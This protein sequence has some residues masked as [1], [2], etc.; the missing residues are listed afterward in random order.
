MG[1]G[2]PNYVGCK[3]LLPSGFHFEYLENKL[4]HY[5]DKQIIQFLRYGFPVDHNRS[6]GVN[7][8]VSNHK[9]ASEFAIQVKEALDREV[10]MG[11]SLG[12]FA[13]AP[14]E[15]TCFSPLNSV[16]K[17]NVE[18]RRL[19]LDLSFPEHNSIN[20]GI[21]KHT[22][23]GVPD[24]MELPSIDKLVERIVKLGKGCK[25]F[26]ID[27]QRAY[28]QVFICPGDFY[29]MSFTFQEM[30]YTDCTLSMGSRSSAKCCQRVSDMVVFIYINDG[31]FAINYLDDFGGADTEQRAWIA[32]QHLKN[33]LLNCGLQEALDKSCPPTTCMTFLGIEVNTITLTLSIPADK[34]LEILEVQA[35]WKEKVVANLRQVQ[36]LAGLLNFACRCIRSGRVY[37][38]RILN[39]L[40]SFND[41]NETK[42][43]P[44]ATLQ[45]VRWWMEFAPLYNGKTLMIENNWSEP[46]EFVCT[47]SSLTGGGGMTSTEFFHFKFSERIKKLCTHIN[48][49][50]AIVLVIAVAR[51]APLF[52]RKKLLLKCDNLNTVL[53]I[54]SSG[55]RDTVMQACLRYLHKILA[56]YSLDI[57]TVHIASVENRLPD[58]LSRW[59]KS[60]KFPKEF[61]QKTAHLKLSEIFISEHEFDFLFRN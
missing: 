9:G 11:G 4:V 47:D 29:L 3:I 43:I 50:E 19:I 18:Q 39:F 42:T 10:G 12:P 55:S 40:R 33:V 51:W 31:F 52:P 23:L 6:T 28:K 8:P 36:K 2:V 14:F 22:Y 35:L 44:K 13:V 27:L 53:A 46:D 49:L 15:K 17:K 25:V 54:N 30:V 26:K 21:P 38:S 5:K 57:K 7:K 58:L 32:Y 59:D 41:K 37:L 16:P 1:S 24:K 48:Q 56:L 20:L 61:V 60:N 45:D 34:L